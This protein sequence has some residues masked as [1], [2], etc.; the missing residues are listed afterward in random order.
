MQIARRS[1]GLPRLFLRSFH[2]SIPQSDLVAPPDPISHIRP[3]IYED[4]PSQSPPAYLRHPYSLSEFNTGE[5]NAP[6]ELEL[7]FK[8][9]RQQLDTFHQ[10]FW[11]DS[12]TRFY[13]AKE[14]VLSSLPQ[15]A[16]ARDSEDAL[17]AFYT[18]WVVQE[19][20]W[21]DDYTKE[22]RKRNNHLIAL[23]ARVAFQ[24]LAIRWSSLFKR[25]SKS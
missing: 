4:S 25:A 6:G 8:L 11:R 24:R 3:I 14:S 10:N 22:W 23:G 15:P 9:Q 2:P 19:K 17:S 16:A 13:A 18:Q 21:T 5:R 7:Q 12:N 20:K 1:V